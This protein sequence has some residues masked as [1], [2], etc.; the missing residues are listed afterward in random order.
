MIKEEL[1][2]GVITNLTKPAS[3]QI[4]PSWLGAAIRSAHPKQGGRKGGKGAESAKESA[5]K[6]A[7]K[8][9]TTIFLICW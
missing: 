7:K 3:H 1:I 5:K 8:S 6:S 4:C 2:L 9:E